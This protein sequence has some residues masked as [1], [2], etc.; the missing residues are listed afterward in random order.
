VSL[1]VTASAPLKLS[2]LY[3]ILLLILISLKNRGNKS[4]RY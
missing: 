4:P 2:D 3:L 1:G